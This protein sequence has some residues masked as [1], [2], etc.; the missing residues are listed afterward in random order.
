MSAVSSAL[1][2]ISVGYQTG[3]SRNLGVTKRNRVGETK[4][5]HH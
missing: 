3:T 4:D 1:I 5:E 2:A